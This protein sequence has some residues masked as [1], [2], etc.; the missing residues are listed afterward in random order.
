[1]THVKCLDAVWG[2]YSPLR[3][4]YR[5]VRPRWMARITPAGGAIHQFVRRIGLEVRHGPFAGLRFPPRADGH[6]SFLA[7]K[8]LGA[9]ERE[10]H[11]ALVEAIAAGPSRVVDVGAAEGYYAV[12]LAMLVDPRIEVLGFETDA[13]GRQVCREM[14]ALNGVEGRVRLLGRCDPDALAAELPDEAFVICDCEGYE[15]ELLDPLR[16]PRLATAT[17]LA[18]LHP[19]ARPEVERVM[20]DR[21]GATHDIVIVHPERREQSEWDE[22]TGV[23]PRTAFRLLSEGAPSPERVAEFRRCWAYMTPCR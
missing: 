6:A 17:I 22:L 20:G 21:F 12:G 2:G 14:A 23:D 19:L 15:V 16:V 7:A 4:T 9:Y 10:I 8:L 11:A 18:E 13:G 5:R 1:V 3:R